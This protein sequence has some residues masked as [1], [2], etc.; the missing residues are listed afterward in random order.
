MLPLLWI[1]YLC[2]AYMERKNSLASQGRLLS[3]RHFGPLFAALLG[4]IPQ[5]GF[6]V[7]AAGLYVERA[8][9][10]GTLLAALIATSDEAIPMLIA[11]PD[12]ASVLWQVLLIKLILAIAVGYGVD[13]FMGRSTVSHPEVQIHNDCG[14]H[15]H[16][17]L[18]GEALIRTVKIYGFIFG[19]SFLFHF[20]IHQI[21][22]DQLRLL[23]LDQSLIQPLLAALI[24]FIPNCA[25]SVLFTSLFMNGVL[26]FGSLIAGLVSNAGLGFIVLIKG[27]KNRKM[28][29]LVALILFFSAWISGSLLQLLSVIG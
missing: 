16:S 21:G 18:F 10:M 27:E 5:C 7:I 3:I 6:S 17:S 13:L 15:E 9:T 26:S 1:T 11:A 19:L 23:L 29:A 24:G 14:S 22:L 12:Q 28:L 8:V 20:I 2:L 25:V 4:L